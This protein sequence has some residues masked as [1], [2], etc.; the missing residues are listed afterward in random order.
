MDRKLNEAYLLDGGLTTKSLALFL[1]YAADAG[2]WSGIPL[3]GGNVCC[4]IWGTEKEARGNLIQ[5]KQ[6]D[7]I[8]TFVAEGETWLSFTERGRALAARHNIQL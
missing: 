3:V 4:G 5:L 6:A 2:N 7:L 1:A 8:T